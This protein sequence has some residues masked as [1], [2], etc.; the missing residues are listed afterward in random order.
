MSSLV[1]IP[2]W[3]EDTDVVVRN[4]NHAASHPRVGEVLCVGREVEST[5]AAIEEAAP[6]IAQSTDT[7]V[8]VI[9]QERIG[10]KRPGKGDGMNT[11][12]LYFVGSDHHRLHFYDADITTFD[13]SWIT[14]T[15]R[16]ADLGHDM[17]RCY[18][19]RSSTDG[20]ITWMITRPLFAKLFWDTPLPRIDQPLGGELLLSRSA[21]EALSSDRRVLDQSDWGIDTALTFTTVDLGLSIYEA[22]IP[23]GK[24][25][26]LYGALTD[27]RTMLIECFEAA[28]G[29]AGTRPHPDSPH[30]VEPPERVPAEI[31]DK[32]GYDKAGTVAL[33]LDSWSDRQSDILSRFPTPIESG[34]KGARNGDVS[35]MDEKRWGLALDTLLSDYQTGDRDWEEMLF[36]LWIIRVLAYS[37]D[38]ATQGYDEAM[39]YLRETIFGYVYESKTG[40]TLD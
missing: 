33:L 21:A 37:Q 8:K 18:F 19:P 2:F 39:R 40:H 7:A 5:Y 34:M 29:F 17:V 13:G 15:E 11:G 3:S 20:M 35:F 24:V 1:V 36:Q 22:Y 10:T 26:K 30:Q 12:L 38:V 25:H 4:V 6:G 14:K 28:K 9:Q 32:V 23:Q 16:A 31:A 27:I